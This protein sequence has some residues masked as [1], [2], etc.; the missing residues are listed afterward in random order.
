MAGSYEIRP[1]LCEREPAPDWSQRPWGRPTVHAAQSDLN[2]KLVGMCEF[3]YHGMRIRGVRVF[4]NENGTLSVNMP[5]KRFGESIESVVYFHD[6][7]E[8]EQFNRDVAWL[9]TS[10]FGRRHKPVEAAAAATG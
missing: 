5:Q 7:I 8:R 10:I 4:R 9:Y 6:P 3:R 2:P 1:E